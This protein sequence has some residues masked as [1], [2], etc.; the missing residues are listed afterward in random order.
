MRALRAI[1]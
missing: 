1:T